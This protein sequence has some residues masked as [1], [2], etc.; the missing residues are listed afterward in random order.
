MVGNSTVNGE[1]GELQNANKCI[2]APAY[3]PGNL[4]LSLPASSPYQTNS[5]EN[6]VLAPWG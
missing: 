4:Q 3:G 1:E 2:A 5:V 6:T